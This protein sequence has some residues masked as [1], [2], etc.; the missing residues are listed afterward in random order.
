LDTIKT[1]EYKLSLFEQQFENSSFLKGR[2]PPSSSFLTGS[3][4]KKEEPSTH[5]FDEAN[6]LRLKSPVRLNDASSNNHN[7]NNSNNW[8]NNT[9]NN[10]N[11]SNANLSPSDDDD[12]DDFK[13]HPSN[14]LNFWNATHSNAT[15]QPGSPSKKNQIKG[16]HH[17]PSKKHL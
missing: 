14:F 11:N 5:A 10:N 4:H 7:N 6:D 12:L 15:R 16:V 13:S 1:L 8:S 3:E 9:S 2:Q 17:S